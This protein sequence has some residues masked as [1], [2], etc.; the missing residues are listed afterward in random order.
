[1]KVCFVSPGVLYSRNLYQQRGSESV[2]LGISHQLVEMGHEIVITGRFNYFNE[3]QKIFDGIEFVN[4]R[5]PNLRD[6]RFHNLASTL[7]YSK[8]VAKILMDMD[9]DV[10]CL[11]ERFSA[12]YPSLLQIPKTF[13]THNP[14]AMDF[15]KKFAWQNNL[16]N[17]FFFNIKQRIEEN[18][19]FNSDKIIA[20]NSYIETYL[21]NKGFYK[22]E[23]IPNAVD[24]KKYYNNG[25]KN[26]ILFAGRLEKVKGI[27]YLINAFS[28]L[29][30]DMNLIII[31]SGPEESN[32]K[33]SLNSEQKNKV[34]FIPH[35]SKIKLQEYLSQCSIFV[36]PSLFET[37]GIV[38][39]EAMASGKPV[40]ASDI[41][42]PRHII[43]HGVNGFLFEKGNEEELIKYL[44]LLIENDNLRKEMGKNARKTVE[45]N[46]SFKKVAEAYLKVF[47]DILV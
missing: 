43:Q 24:Y 36:L 16:I 46:Y 15:Y 8:R 27:N 11:N 32:L 44:K 26:F 33:K 19:I 47:N 30:D 10:L 22:T 5:S 39:I 34:E 2:I 7:L 4:I 18:I 42:G 12:Y 38:L 9:I 40:I 14:D 6:H 20:L 28:K 1:M 21:N 45:D 13:T 25:D 23:V 41:P 35:L 3:N 29:S 37:F 31:G 17:L